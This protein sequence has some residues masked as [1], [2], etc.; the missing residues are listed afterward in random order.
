MKNK[1]SHKVND[2]KRSD[3]NDKEN[4]KVFCSQFFDY[5]PWST[6][7]KQILQECMNAEFKEANIKNPT[8]LWILQDR[9]LV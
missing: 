5:T 6:S 4:S 9:Q 8:P 1:Q 7:R 2:N 3:D